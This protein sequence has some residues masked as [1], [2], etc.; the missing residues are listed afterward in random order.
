VRLTIVDGGHNVLDTTTVEI[1]ARGGMQLNDIFGARGLT[2]PPAALLLVEVVEGQ[3][4]AAYATVTDNVTND[5]IYL[6]SQLAAKE[7][8]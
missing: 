1:P 4:I 6:A 7:E 5:S 8:N 2:P 3:Q